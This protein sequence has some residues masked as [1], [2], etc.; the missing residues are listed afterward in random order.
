MSGQHSTSSRRGVGPGPWIFGALVL[1]CWHVAVATT[2]GVVGAEDLG[3]TVH[4]LT[5]LHPLSG[6]P[7]DAPGQVEVLSAFALALVI[8]AVVGVWVLIALGRRHKRPSGKGMADKHDVERFFGEDRARASAERTR[9]AL[10]QRE[11]RKASTAEF[12][13]VIGVEKSSR[14][15]VVLSFEDHVAI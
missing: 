6:L 4:A 1:L 2:S 5:R 14:R 9:P 7:G 8:G 15:P 11:R 13:L 10:N 3:M 12:G